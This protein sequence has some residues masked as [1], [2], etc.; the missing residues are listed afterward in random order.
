MRTTLVIVLLLGA[1]QTAQQPPWAPKNLRYFPQDITRD[2]LV[3]RMREF[4]FALNVRCQYCHAGGDGI[5]FDGVDFASDDK[6]AK[7]KARA[8]LKMMDTINTSLLAE[9]PSRAEPRV[10]VTC[11]TCHH[12]LPLP[13]SLQ[14]TLFEI[15]QKDGAAAAVARYKELRADTTMGRYNFGQWE[16]MELARRLNEAKN[17]SA[18][19]AILE[20]TGEYYPKSPDVDIHIGEIRLARGETDL[21][22]TSLRRALEKAPGD[23][24]LKARIAELEKK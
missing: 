3:Q 12:G 15:A 6:P 11:S 8:M 22:L 1:S 19:I 4:S 20:M 21:A 13:K 9:I 7:V 23:A 24:R 17:T 10:V 14:T 16:T 18:A 2:A 5:S